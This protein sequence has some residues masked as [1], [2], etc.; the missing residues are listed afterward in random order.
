MIHS[1]DEE[2]QWYKGVHSQKSPSHLAWPPRFPCLSFSGVSLSWGALYSQGIWTP[3]YLFFLLF[4]IFLDRVT[5]SPDCMKNYFELPILLPPLPKYWDF[6]G[7]ATRS[8]SSIFTFLYLP[9]VCIHAY[10]FTF[11]WPH[12][13][14]IHV[15]RRVHTWGSPKLTA[16]SSISLYL[17]HWGRVSH[18]NPEL[19][20]SPSL[21]S[22]LAQEVPSPYT[23]CWD[24]FSWGLGN[25]AS[26]HLKIMVLELGNGGSHL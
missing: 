13:W 20:C 24:G 11:M 22:Q 17:I 8:G 25:P 15:Y 9:V 5:Y 10:Y 6:R 7:V 3:T 2:F 4:W 21:A 1:Q 19:A 14:G 23:S 16:N 26:R 12:A 18:L